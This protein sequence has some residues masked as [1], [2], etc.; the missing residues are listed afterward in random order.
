ML[1]LFTKLA[2]NGSLARLANRESEFNKKVDEKVTLENQ[3]KDRQEKRVK[4]DLT[5]MLVMV[6]DYIKANCKQEDVSRYEEYADKK[7]KQ[8]QVKIDQIKDEISN[9][10]AKKEVI[11]GSETAKTLYKRYCHY[12]HY[13]PKAYVH[14]ERLDKMLK[15]HFLSD[16]FIAAT[17]STIRMVKSRIYHA[18]EVVED[19][20]S[21]YDYVEAAARVDRSMSRLFDKLHENEIEKLYYEKFYVAQNRDLNKVADTFDFEGSKL[22]TP[23]ITLGRMLYKAVLE[24]SQ[25]DRSDPFLRG[26]R[27]KQ[28]EYITNLIKHGASFTVSLDPKNSFHIL[29][30]EEIHH[31]NC[32]EVRKMIVKINPYSSEALIKQAII[33]SRKF[34]DYNIIVSL[35]K[36]NIRSEDAFRVAMNTGHFEVATQLLHYFPR[37]NTNLQDY[38]SEDMIKRFMTELEV[39]IKLY[40]QMKSDYQK[41]FS[42]VKK[43]FE[44]NEY[45]ME[46]YKLISGFEEGHITQNNNNYDKLLEVATKVYFEFLGNDKINDFIEYRSQMLEN[47]KALEH[48]HTLMLKLNDLC[49]K[50][51]LPETADKTSKRGRYEM[52]GVGGLGIHLA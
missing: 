44:E 47:A 1:L 10:R 52:L 34:Y 8:L 14:I 33:A 24:L 3:I 45:F 46:G 50:K 51:L 42:R 27:G 48:R 38:V 36:M 28:I 2:R 39:D 49:G 37:L 20:K 22:I 21:F 25:L 29:E 40:S 6:S 9:V 17:K 16:E 32:S 43:F 35:C 4:E 31:I 15:E 18:R 11:L 19:I 30:C 26:V 13:I 23:S 7:V 12:K 41:E 5:R